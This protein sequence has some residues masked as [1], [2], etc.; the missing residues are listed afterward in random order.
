MKDL[1]ASSCEAAHAAL[2]ALW[3][4]EADPV[5]QAVAEAHL[6]ECVACRKEAEAQQ[7]F[8]PALREALPVVRA[9]KRL[10]RRVAAPPAAPRPWQRALQAAAALA[11]ALL[12]AVGGGVP[13][14]QA[15]VPPPR[16]ASPADPPSETNPL[17]ADDAFEEET[18]DELIDSLTE[19]EA[20]QLFA[21]LA[22][23]EP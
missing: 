1:P 6:A 8:L 15:A 11:A 5:E 10:K 20:E 17:L 13:F 3:S 9:P 22:E 14:H 21:R 4:G 7:R 19:A 12:F 18:L 2:G 23:L 16:N